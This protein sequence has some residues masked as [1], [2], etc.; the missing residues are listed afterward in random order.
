MKRLILLIPLMF[1]LFSCEKEFVP[2][3]ELPDWLLS[4][5]EEDEEVISDRPKGYLASGTWVR[6]KWND[7][8]YYEYWNMLS[9]RFAYPI[10]HDRDTLDFTIADGW[11]DY[12]KEKC[13]EKFVW[14]GPEVKDW[15]YDK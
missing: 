15:M 1:I 8:F 3:H 9:S 5:I 2:E 6:V 13:C 7:V 12:A 10:S 14:K 4:K 11:T